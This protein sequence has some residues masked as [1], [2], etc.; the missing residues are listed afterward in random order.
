MRRVRLTLSFL[1]SS[2]VMSRVEMA[3]ACLRSRLRASMTAG[4]GDRPRTA[5]GRLHA[6]PS[7]TSRANA[8]RFLNEAINRLG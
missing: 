2:A 1:K 6:R 3:L 8:H 4:N 5:E 7:G